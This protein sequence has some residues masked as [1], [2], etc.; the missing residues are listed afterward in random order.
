MYDLRI[1]TDLNRQE[2]EAIF[3]YIVVRWLATGLPVCVMANDWRLFITPVAT[4]I[5]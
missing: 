4:N 1:W 3:Y 5:D 2:G